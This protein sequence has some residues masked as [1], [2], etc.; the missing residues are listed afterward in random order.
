MTQFVLREKIRR[1]WVLLFLLN[2]RIET[3]FSFNVLHSYTISGIATTFGLLFIT[4]LFIFHRSPMEECSCFVRRTNCSMCIFF[5][6]GDQETLRY[7]T[8]TI[9]RQVEDLLPRLSLRSNVVDFENHLH[10]L[11]SQANLLLFAN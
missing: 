5:Q 3:L 11:G 7:V 1:I 6:Q 8:E 9:S 10:Q 4:K 2:M